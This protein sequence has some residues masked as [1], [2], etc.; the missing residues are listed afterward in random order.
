[1]YRHCKDSFIIIDSRKILNINIKSQTLTHPT[2][3]LCIHLIPGLK[4]SAEA[5]LGTNDWLPQHPSGQ[6]TST[7]ANHWR[8]MNC[9]LHSTGQKCR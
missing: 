5:H 1:M 6:L 4:T 2:H 8:A 9:F 7:P 3:S